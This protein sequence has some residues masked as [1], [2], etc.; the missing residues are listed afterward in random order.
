MSNTAVR[1]E[2]LTKI[3]KGELGQKDVLG[4]DD[5][6]LE[7]MEGGVFAFLG[8]NGA[9]K[10]TTIKLMTRLI[11]ATKGKVWILGRQND[12]RLAME[13]VGYLPEQPQMYGYLTGW[14]FLDFIGR[15]FGLD[16]KI[17]G[18][19]VSTLLAKVGLTDKG[20]VSI[21]GYSRGMMQRLGFAQALMNDPKLLILD[22][23][24]ASLDPVG[25]KDF[26]D[27]ILELRD[28][29][30][31]IFFSSHILSDA[32]LVAD[33]VGILNEG[34]LVSVGKLDELVGSQ[35]NSVDI[36]FE[37]DE[38]KLHK[39]KLDTEDIIQSGRKVMIRLDDE[40]VV[41]EMLKRIDRGGGRIV[42]VVPQRKTLEEVFI[43]EVG[44]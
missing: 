41:P 1:V 43:G 33:R 22:E 24:M 36:T 2:A 40:N 31:T 27:M 15:V 19:R 20:D 3:Y 26:R 39:I 28:R 35:V 42:S 29:G 9:G 7:V 32:E 8:P 11:Y 30:K 16:T 13:S 37:V 18:E 14:E 17:R 12:T 5:L 21:R 23:P 34:R 10:T 38:G 6:N 4:L 44:R 25:R